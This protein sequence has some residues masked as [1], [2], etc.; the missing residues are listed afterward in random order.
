VKIQE[1]YIVWKLLTRFVFGQDKVCF[2]WSRRCH[3]FT[4]M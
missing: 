4:Q 2:F 1:N 3:R